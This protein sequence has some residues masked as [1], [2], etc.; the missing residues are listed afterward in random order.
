VQVAGGAG[1]GAVLG[2]TAARAGAG[3]SAPAG[4]EPDE[5][6]RR[7]ETRTMSGLENAGASTNP[8]SVAGAAGGIAATGPAGLAAA[9]AYTAQRAA[10]TL[11]G[12]MEQMAGYGGM[13]G[14][15]PYAQPA[16]TPRPAG[17]RARPVP[18]VGPPGMPLPPAGPADPAAP[19][20]PPEMHHEPPGTGA[21]DPEDT[22]RGDE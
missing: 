22:E 4:I 18:A 20:A 19:P 12:R 8:A 11:T 1:L 3:P 14:A 16:G 17:H 21:D 7:L 9:A 6:S 2:F 10:N 5:F 13:P 15:N